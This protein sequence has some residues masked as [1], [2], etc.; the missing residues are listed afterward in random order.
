M[1]VLL[2]NIWYNSGVEFGYDN[3][4]ILLEF[5]LVKVCVVVYSLLKEISKMFWNDMGRILDRES[6]GVKCV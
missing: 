1:A 6:R 2:S 5:V 4:R 3:A